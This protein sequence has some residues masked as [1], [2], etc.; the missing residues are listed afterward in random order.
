VEQHPLELGSKSKAV[1]P[2]IRLQ[3]LRL[4][5]LLFACEFDVATAILWKKNSVALLDVKR[6]NISFLVLDTRTDF[7]DSS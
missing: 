5:G 1:Y 7:N 2:H 6:D 3:K 4:A